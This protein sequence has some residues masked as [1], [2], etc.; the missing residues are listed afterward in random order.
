MRKCSSQS[1][2]SAP[3]NGARLSSGCCTAGAGRAVEL[4]LTA[5]VFRAQEAKDMYGALIL[6]KAAALPAQEE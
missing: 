6:S 5:R 3:R 4:A 2:I 1:R